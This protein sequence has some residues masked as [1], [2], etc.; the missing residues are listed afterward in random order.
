MFWSG[1]DGA[2]GSVTS[3]DDRTTEI[4]VT[5]ACGSTADCAHRATNDRASAWP[6][7][8]HSANR[9]T[10]AS[11]EQATRKGAVTLGIAA[12]GKTKAGNKKGGYR[13]DT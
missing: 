13:K 3:V 10:C 8:G 11:A 2:P 1:I 7:A 4:D 5:R 12:R 6:N 9:R